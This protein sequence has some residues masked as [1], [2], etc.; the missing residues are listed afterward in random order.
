MSQHAPLIATAGPQDGRR[1]ERACDQS[2]SAARRQSETTIATQIGADV[3]SVFIVHSSSRTVRRVV[4]TARHCT[5]VVACFL[6]LQLPNIVWNKIYKQRASI[7]YLFSVYKQNSV[8]KNENMCTAEITNKPIGIKLRVI[9]VVR[10]VFA[11]IVKFILSL[12][13]GVEGEK[14]PPIYDEILKQPAVVVARKIRN[15]E[16]SFIS[17]CS[18]HKH[19]CLCVHTPHHNNLR[20]KLTNYTRT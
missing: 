14:I 18:L 1:S 13:Y 9:H 16:A 15:K 3:S 12:Y 5:S 8:F 19:S 10:S 4:L 11:T 17:I 6:P 7:V 2:G 20:V